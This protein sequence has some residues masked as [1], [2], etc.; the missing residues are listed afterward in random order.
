MHTFANPRSGKEQAASR[1]AVGHAGRSWGSP[2]RL[3]W[4]ALLV[5]FILLQPITYNIKVTINHF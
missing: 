4:G 2:L 3:L 1:V 5:H